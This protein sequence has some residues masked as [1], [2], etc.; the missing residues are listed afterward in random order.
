MNLS[1]EQGHKVDVIKISSKFLDKTWISRG[2][3][4]DFEDKVCTN[5][6]Q[7]QKQDKMWTKI[8]QILDIDKT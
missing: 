5:L 8:G 4:L 1:F 6:G 2:Q 7:E 3:K